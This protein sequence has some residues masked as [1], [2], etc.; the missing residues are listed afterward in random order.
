MLCLHV[1]S[2]CCQALV[3]RAEDVIHTLAD[4]LPPGDAQTRE[5]WVQDLDRLKENFHSAVE[6][7]RQTLGAV[8]DFYHYYN[9]VGILL[10]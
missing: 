8:A 3:H 2:P 1:F 10:D 7:P 9:K 5:E 4:T 6:L